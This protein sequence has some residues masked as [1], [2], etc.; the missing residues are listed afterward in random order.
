MTLRSANGV[1]VSEEL[2]NLP[3]VSVS[4][5]V[6]VAYYQSWAL[7]LGETPTTTTTVT[8]RAAPGQMPAGYVARRTNIKATVVATDPGKPSVTFKGPTG[9]QVEVDV[10]DDPRVLSRL[11]VGETYD[12]SYTESIIV[13]VTKAPR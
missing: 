3:Q 11:K 6:T 2:R 5:I 4:D 7:R 12:V 9:N 10:S 13:A 8:G 1:H